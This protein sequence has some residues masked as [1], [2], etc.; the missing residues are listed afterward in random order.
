M[1]G[2]AESNATR[3][4]ETIITRAK[5]AAALEAEKAMAGTTQRLERT[6]LSE[7]AQALLTAERQRD[8]WRK[9]FEIL[10]D[11]IR[12][13]LPEQLYQRIHQQATAR[14]ERANRVE[15]T[16]PVRVAPRSS[17]PSGP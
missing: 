5:H 12:T 1:R 7:G 14:W 17:G 10:L 4:G 3:L 6:L 2:A 16:V 15:P 13:L 11:C 8:G 9:R